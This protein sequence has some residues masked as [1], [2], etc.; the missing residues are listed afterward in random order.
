MLK[1][2]VSAKTFKHGVLAG[3]GDLAVTLSPAAGAGFLPHQP[4]PDNARELVGARAGA[5][6]RPSCRSG[7]ARRSPARRLFPAAANWHRCQP[8]DALPIRSGDT[9]PAQV[10]AGKIGAR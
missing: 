2:P 7:T 6:P 3:K 10:P 9:E 8:G 4:F 1:L 5:A